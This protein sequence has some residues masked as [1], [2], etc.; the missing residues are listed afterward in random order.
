ML[1]LEVGCRNV[2]FPRTNA[3][4]YNKLDPRFRGDD[5]HSRHADATAGRIALAAKLP[6][7]RQD[8]DGMTRL[9]REAKARTNVAYPT[10]AKKAEIAHVKSPDVEF[11]N[12]QD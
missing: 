12:R 8:A 9:G 4:K 3:K 1:V 5:N 11:P 7:P 10:D 6:R 2:N